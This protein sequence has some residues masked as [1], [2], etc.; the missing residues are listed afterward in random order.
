ME[1]VH[2]LL[3]LELRVKMNVIKLKNLLNNT[4]AVL[5]NGALTDSYLL[6]LGVPEVLLKNIPPK[7]E[8]VEEPHLELVNCYLLSVAVSKFRAEEIRREFLDALDTGDSPDVL[9]TGPSYK[10]LVPLLGDAMSVLQLFAVGQCLQLWQVL[11]PED[12][13]IEPEARDAAALLGMVNIT[14]YPYSIFDTRSAAAQA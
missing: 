5:S 12:F 8:Y 3:F 6:E 4:T 1:S 2:R 14:G 11:T 13:N 9:S 10:H 7:E